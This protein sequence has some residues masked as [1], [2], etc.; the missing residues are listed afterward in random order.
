MEI[1][2][3]CLTTPG[4]FAREFSCEEHATAWAF[5]LARELGRLQ[6]ADLFRNHLG[7]GMIN[8]FVQDP[9]ISDLCLLGEALEPGEFRQ[10]VT[11]Q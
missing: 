4:E 11:R 5:C 9:L 3:R 8:G 10:L 7:A 1:K 2:L 6:E